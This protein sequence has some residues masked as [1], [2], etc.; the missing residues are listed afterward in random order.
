M[1]IKSILTIKSI[2]RLN[3]NKIED[4]KKQQQNKEDLIIESQLKKTEQKTLKLVMKVIKDI[5]FAMDAHMIHI[6][7]SAIQLA[8]IK[9]L[10]RLQINL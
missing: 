10:K 4:N 6:E 7:F 2:G 1:T 8:N 9:Q 5:I 3:N